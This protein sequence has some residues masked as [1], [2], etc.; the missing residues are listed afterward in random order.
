M[1]SRTGWRSVWK[2]GGLFLVG[3]SLLG[4]GGCAGWKVF[5]KATEPPPAELKFSTPSIRD[6]TQVFRANG[7]IVPALSTEI[8][9]EI[10]GIIA[11]IH[12]KPGDTVK[13][14]QPLLDLDQSEIQL[15]MTELRLQIESSRLRAEKARSLFERRSMLS[16]KSF[17]NEKDLADVEIDARLAG[18]DLAVHEARLKT[19]EVQLS[20]ASIVAPYEGVV[21]D[22][23]ARPGLVV[24]GAQAGR[25]GTTLM[26]I[27]DLSRLKVEAE[28]NEVDVASLQKGMAVKLGFD[29]A[30]EV[31]VEGVLEYIS[32]S[33]LSR[34][35][36][37]ASSERAGRGG[38]AERGAAIRNFPIDI[39]FQ[40]GD[41]RIRPGMTAKM[42]VSLASAK[43]V[44]S[45]EIGAVFTEEGE[46]VAYVQRGA[47]LV[48]RP[49]KTG[50]ND[51]QY[52][53][54]LEGLD[55]AVE[56]E[57]WALSR[58]LKVQTEEERKARLARKKS[59]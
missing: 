59:R 43:Q 17:I 32:P 27:A 13:A 12:V 19:E 20:K 41:P 5:L 47:E 24:T 1:R 4:W 25:E 2:K 21:L 18:I 16:A 26:T 33:A 48:R 52:V 46:T 39:G 53:E 9:S 54:L 30:P 50:V 23:L 14:G 29:A 40:I 57:K 51:S 7:N 28:I 35:E 37:S 58:P 11:R 49:V 6:I 31:S 3:A 44:R 15:R 38:A 22:L 34:R 36:L 8:R 55:G 56:G 45:V 10:T 42:E